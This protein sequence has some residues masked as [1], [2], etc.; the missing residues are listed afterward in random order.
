MPLADVKQAKAYFRKQI[1]D[2]FQSV[3]SDFV[4]MR[5]YLSE[6]KKQTVERSDAQS[7]QID[8]L[9]SNVLSKIKDH[10][11]AIESGTLEIFA[12][13][14]HAH[15]AVTAEHRAALHAAMRPPKYLL[16]TVLDRLRANPADYRLALVGFWLGVADVSS[17]LA[18]RNISHTRWRDGAKV[19]D[20]IFEELKL[21]EDAI[22][23]FK[24]GVMRY[25]ASSQFTTVIHNERLVERWHIGDV[26]HEGED[27][28]AEAAAD[29]ADDDPNGGISKTIEYESDAELSEK[30]ERKAVELTRREAASFIKSMDR[31]SGGDD[32]DD[33]NDDGDDDEDDKHVDGDTT[34]QP[35]LASVP[36]PRH[37]LQCGGKKLR[38]RTRAQRDKLTQMFSMIQ[39]EPVVDKPNGGAAG[40]DDAEDT[41]EDYTFEPEKSEDSDFDEDDEDE[42]SRASDDDG[43]ND[44]DDEDNDGNDDDGNDDA[45]DDDDDD[46]QPPP[47]KK[48]QKMTHPDGSAIHGDKTT[49]TLPKT[50][51]TDMPTVQYA[52]M[53]STTATATRTNGATTGVTISQM[54][55]SSHDVATKPALVR[56]SLA[57][58]A[59][60][61]ALP[62]PSEST[63][64]TAMPVELSDVNQDVANKEDDDEEDTKEDES[65]DNPLDLA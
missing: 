1:E 58:A 46:K 26:T 62:T 63:N 13:C 35:A 59:V 2:A 18:L 42:A 45:G 41:V 50:S 9:S 5:K 10:F 49:R 44:D 11:T 55:V 37:Y 25:V 8:L 21:Y 23:K 16:I 65:A 30:D 12:E 7:K 32:D 6:F 17:S 20:A 14:A 53:K 61:L 4:E 52:T 43:N 22:R 15:F 29:A 38:K 33:E 36:A 28:L 3:V 27:R 60:P 24:V 39:E 51:Q 47:P 19:I 57:I 31:H 48:Q 34:T 54:F 64:V 40:G 56:P